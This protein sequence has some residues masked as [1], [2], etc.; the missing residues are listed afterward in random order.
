MTSL[1]V[2][3]PLAAITRF[4]RSGWVASYPESRTATFT[5]LPVAPACQAA[6]APICATLRSRAGLMP[7]FRVDRAGGDEWDRVER[8]HRL[9]FA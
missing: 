8:D 9:L 1:S 6:G 4:F 7:P 2:V 3:N 5:P